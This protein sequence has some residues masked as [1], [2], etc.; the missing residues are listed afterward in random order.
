MLVSSLVMLCVW[1][2]EFWWRLIGVRWK[3]K[4]W[5]LCSNCCN[6][7]LVSLVLLFSFSELV[8]I[9]RLVCRVLGLL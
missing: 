2:F 5:M 3:L 1:I 9:L 7:L 6:W 8:S 4:I